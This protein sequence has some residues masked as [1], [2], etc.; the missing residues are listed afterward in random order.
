M[1]PWGTSFARGATALTKITAIHA[2]F[3]DLEWQQ[4]NRLAQGMQVTDPASKWARVSGE[5]VSQRNRYL[6]VDPYLNHRIR[7]KVPEGHSD[8]I[9]ASPIT[10]HSKRTGLTSH[11]IATQ[12]P[13]EAS[14]SH[15]WR[16]IWHE[17]GPVA[18]I[19]MLTQIHEQGK[20]KCFQYFPA[21]MANP[22]VAINDD[23]EFGDGFIGSITLLELTEDPRTRS[24]IRK[25][26]LDIGDE[27]KTVWHLLFSGWPDFLVPEGEDRA[28]LLELVKV[29]AALNDGET[30]GSDTVNRSHPDSDL[31]P[32]PR[33]V[34]CSAGVG[35]SGTFIALDHLTNELSLGALDGLPEDE[36]PISGSVDELRKQRMMMVQGEPQFHFLYEVLRESWAAHHGLSD[37]IFGAEP[38]EQ[39]I[40][41]EPEVK[42]PRLE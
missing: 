29:S 16:M 36:D 18:V 28:A 10:L 42:V 7:L 3:V 12:G 22:T 27:S 41:Q 21:D 40:V 2:S 9:N 20:E 6:N 34:H 38:V 4:R 31:K 5:E 19:V 30:N 23:D 33:I 25:M 8:Y 24:T 11:Y 32:N 17:T 37:P 35:R 1:K 26:Q 14:S 15:I 39:D 13:K